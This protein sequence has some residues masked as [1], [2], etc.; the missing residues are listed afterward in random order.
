MKQL[1][2]GIL[3]L[4]ITSLCYA[5]ITYEKIDEN[6]IKKI[7]IVE[8]IIDLKALQS[9]IDELNEQ[10]KDMPDEILMP[11]GKEMLIQER[12]EKV[13]YLNSITAPIAISK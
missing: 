3:V 11:S 2:T 5:D 13:I 1:L 10:I 12:D 8:T 4:C 7:K 9:E 6:T